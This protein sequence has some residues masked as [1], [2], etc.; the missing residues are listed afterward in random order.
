MEWKRGTRLRMTGDDEWIE[1][2]LADLADKEFGGSVSWC[3]P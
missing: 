2:A 3:A 1:R